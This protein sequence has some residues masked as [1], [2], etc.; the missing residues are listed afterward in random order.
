MPALDYSA[1]NAKVRYWMSFLIDEAKKEELIHSSLN[2]VVN[3]IQTSAHKLPVETEDVQEIESLLKQSLVQYV[4]SAKRFVS[5]AARD[6]LYEWLRSYELENLKMV[7]RSLLSGRP[8][9]FLYNTGRVSRIDMSLETIRGFSSLDDFLDYLR[10]TEYYALAKESLP[11][12]KEEKNTFYWE[13]MLDNFFALK[14]HKV[15]QSLDGG[16]LKAV[17]ELSFYSLEMNRVFWLY[18]L[19][20]HYGFSVEET[21]AYIPN[22]L[23]VITKNR[24]QELL[25][26]ETTQEFL[27]KLVQWKLLDQA[28]EGVI[29]LEAVFN[30][31]IRKRAARAIRGNPFSFGILLSFILIKSQNIRW[32]I[33]LLEAKQ[34][35]LA[36]EALAKMLN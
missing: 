23:K 19:R 3:F 17:Q 22:L 1:V 4:V 18:R 29:D 15:A 2:D 30:Q 33:I 12:V 24:Y 16:S 32:L 5:G 10:N 21:M 28:V 8:L 14:L 9:T 6:Y 36:N 34:S 26:S 13:I 20:Y 35:G 31:S 7:A 11:R 25:Y 27:D